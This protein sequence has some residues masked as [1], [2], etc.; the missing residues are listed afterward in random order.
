M[1]AVELA[2]ELTM[3][4]LANQNTRTNAEDVPAVLQKMHAAI[5][6]LGSPAA[7]EESPA[8]DYAPAVSVRRSLASPDHIVSMIDGKPYRTLK[9]HL[10][11]N[12]LTPAEY[13]ERFGLKPD[14]PMAPTYSAARAAMARS[15]G[16]GQKRQ[17]SEGVAPAARN[18]RSS[19]ATSAQGCS[20]ALAWASAS[21][22]LSSRT[23]SRPSMIYHCGTIS[24]GSPAL[25][26]RIADK[27]PITGGGR[28]NA[29]CSAAACLRYR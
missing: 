24:L 21:L 27:A 25:L 19:K 13:R 10:K 12:G 8:Q 9:R 23:R 20:E 2:T 3:A 28:A 26:S 15:I 17:P 1:N 22:T 14:Y 7:P 16:L 18:K 5:T 29:A 11:G 4:W 6:V